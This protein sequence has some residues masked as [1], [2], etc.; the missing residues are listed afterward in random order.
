MFENPENWEFNA[1]LNRMMHRM[2]DT[3]DKRDGSVIYNALAPSALELASMFVNLQI[4]VEQTYILT[5]T[6]ENL[7]NLGLSFGVARR[8]STKALRRGLFYG[9][10]GELIDV[11]IG[12]MFATPTILGR[13]EAN[14]FEVIYF[15]SVG[16]AILRA[17]EYG[18]IGNIYFG[19]ILPASVQPNLTRAELLEVI[20]PAQ[21]IETDESYRQRI[22]ARFTGQS[23]GGN[24]PQY[25]E[26]SKNI[27]GV[28]NVKVFPIWDGGG[29]V[30]L[31]V[32]DTSYNPI[33]EQFQ[34]HIRNEFDP[35]D[36]TA[37]GEGI[38]PIG[39]SVTVT[40]PDKFD[41][42]VEFTV[43]LEG[44]VV[45]QVRQP[46][47]DALEEYFLILRSDWMQDSQSSIFIARIINVVLGVAGVVNVYDVLL[48]GEARDIILRDTPE[49]QNLP[50][51]GEVTINVA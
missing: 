20:Q 36:M 9:R 21:D 13:Q 41:V 10:D 7:D 2:P 50:F 44:L 19:G 32:I 39:H 17:V 48:N 51:L 37:M 22:Y 42:D 47:I 40:T 4:F 26:W 12:S 27:D 24:I 49:L 8:G 25:I 45:G 28:G 31:S 46:I 34:E 38:S 35:Q 1:I 16:D 3:F 15:T 18:S 30:K 14:L 5:A 33:S 11:A 6:G 29:T 23:F 43:Q